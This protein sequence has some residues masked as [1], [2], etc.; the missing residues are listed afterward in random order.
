MI[1][2]E[3][4]ERNPST[5]FDEL[6]EFTELLKEDYRD[7]EEIIE[8]EGPQ[9]GSR[10]RVTH[11]CL[12]PCPPLAEY[13]AVKAFVEQAYG[14]PRLTFAAQRAAKER[15]DKG[16]SEALWELIIT[17]IPW[18]FRVAQDYCCDN[19]RMDEFLDYFQEGILGLMEAVKRWDPK[20]G[21]LQTYA[22]VWILQRMQRYEAN[23]GAPLRLPVH[24]QEKRRKVLRAIQETGSL[25]PDADRN[26]LAR[27][28][29]PVSLN[30]DLSWIL[31]TSIEDQALC[32]KEEPLPDDEYFF[33]ELP[34]PY[35]LEDEIVE[36]I[37][38]E[39]VR[40]WLNSS[41]MTEREKLV[42]CERYGLSDGR[43]KTL[44]EVGGFLGVTRERVRQIEAKA[45]KKLRH[46]TRLN[47][48]RVV[49]RP[50]RMAGQDRLRTG[51][52]FF[53]G[54]S[55]HE[56]QQ[57]EPRSKGLDTS[58]EIRLVKLAFE[59]LLG[60]VKP[61]RRDYA[62]LKELNDAEVEHFWRSL[63]DVRAL[64]ECL[65]K[66]QQ[67]VIERTIEQERS[68]DSYAVAFMKRALVRVYRKLYC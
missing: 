46:H 55:T 36:R 32:S 68:P 27:W 19:Q 57:E 12:D 45:L 66:K 47:A 41:G 54:Y 52:S 23:Q 9:Q 1:S 42:I 3:A 14:L 63:F 49:D 43:E 31:Q 29:A 13:P 35:S 2:E 56:S 30:S 10:Y 61:S 40:R 25:P 18:A 48:I 15:L 38:R 51:R 59:A 7:I 26:E 62:W 65:T 11:V 4:N 16:D 28:L 8:E 33:E 37:Y 53:Q 64:Q 67:K 17:G 6:K 22:S 44:E 34:T 58:S 24:V 50:H 5:E 39:E 21:P 60:T 20:E